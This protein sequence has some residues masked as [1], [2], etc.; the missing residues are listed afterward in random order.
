MA[1]FSFPAIHSVDRLSFFQEYRHLG[2]S[3][4]TVKKLAGILSTIQPLSAAA[5]AAARA[6]HTRLTKPPGSLGRLETL[7]VQLAGICNTTDLRLAHKLIVVM[8]ADHGVTAN[9]VSAFPQE[10]TGQMVGNFLAGGAAINVLVRLAGAQLLIVDMGVASDLPAHPHL[11]RRPLARSTADMTQGPAMSRE[12]A[13][14]AIEVGIALVAEASVPA[15]D[16]LGTGEMGIGNTTAAA[17]VAAAIT[18]APAYELV[19]RGTGVDEQGLAR[20]VAA[21]EQA[22]AVNCPDP[23]DPVDVLAKVGG[24]EIGGLA[25]AI[26]GAA[27][28]RRP[29]LVDGYIATAAA[30]LAVCLAPQVKPYLIAAHCSREQGH[31]RMLAWLGLEPLLSL[32]LCLGEGSGAALA[33]PLVEAACRLLTEMATF[34]SAGV[35][36]QTP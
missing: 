24:F 34:D 36:E 17:A 3:V 18:G 32:D 29:I 6:R 14:C 33:M 13:V 22:L 4:K 25:G 31:A 27:A 7:A 21:V 28:R 2:E 9:R 15:L 16:I 23:N 19:G 35:A 11:I 26:L 12:Q 10:V 8:A 5:Q 30:M 20:K 1:G